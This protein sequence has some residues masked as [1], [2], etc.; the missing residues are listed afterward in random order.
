MATASPSEYLALLMI[1]LEQA[2]RDRTVPA[3]FWIV[4][5]HLTRS[6][7]VLCRGS[8]EIRGE[9][10]QFQASWPLGELRWEHYGGLVN[11]FVGDLEVVYALCPFGYSVEE[12][13]A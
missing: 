7:D 10:P 11:R 8:I 2:S 1:G 3:S 12:V 9:M 5:D 4:D 13:L 6:V